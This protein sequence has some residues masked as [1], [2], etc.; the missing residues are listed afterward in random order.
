MRSTKQTILS[1]LA[2]TALA[3]CAFAPVMADDTE[4]FMVQPANRV[5]PNVLII[6]DTSGSMNLTAEETPLPYDPT[7]SYGPASG[8]DTTE[9]RNDR[10]YYSRNATPPKSCRNLSYIQLS[11]NFSAAAPREIKCQAAVKHLAWGAGATGAGFYTDRFI[12][13]RGSGKNRG[14][15]ADLTNGD[16]RTTASDVECLE[17]EG[18]H[19]ADSSSPGTYPDYRTADSSNGRWTN[20]S[21]DSWWGRNQGY[22]TTLYSPN[23]IRYLAY[24]SKATQTR[25]DVVR[26]AAAAFLNALPNLNVG[27][28]R[29]SAN[30]HTYPLSGNAAEEAAA[31]GMVMSPV[32]PLDPKRAS[33][34]ADITNASG[35]NLYL[36]HGYTPLSETLYEAYL[37][38]SGGPVH[39]GQSSRLCTRVDTRPGDNGTCAD[40]THMRNYPSVPESMSDGRYISPITSS[41]QTNY[42]VYLTDGEARQDTQ[43]NQA[44]AALTGTS[45]SGDGG[46]LANLT[47][48]MFE[49]D[50]IPDH[51][52]P[53]KQNVRTYFIGFGPDFSGNPQAFN[54][55]VTA[56][57]LGGGQAYQAD[58]LSSLTSVFNSIVTSILQ[59]S[60]T[61]TTPTVAVNA[62]NRTQ[63]LDDLFVSVFQPDNAAHWPGNLKKYR[64][65]DG[66]IVDSEGRAAVDPTTGFFADSARS[67]WSSRADGANVK[68]GGAANRIP[69]PEQR[70]LYTY[71]GAQRPGSAVPLSNHPLSTSNSDL[72]EE[73]LDLLAPGD[74][75]RDD[76]INWAR[77]ADVL[78]EDGDA[79]TNVRRAMGDPLHSPPAVVIYGGTA[80]SPDAVV[81]V[82]TNDGYLH[83]FD[84]ET[85]VELWAYV[86]QELL[87]RLKTLY[88][89]N[90]VAQRTYGLDSPITVL[91]YD[92]N[93][94]G[95]VN[96]DDRVIL[97]F[98]MGR[99]GDRYYA[100][101]V[102][103]KNR[104]RYL[105]SI[106]PEVLPG[107]GQTWSQ[108]TVARV[109][110][111]GATQNSQKLVL[112]AG[113]GYDVTQDSVV[114]GEDSVGNRLYM[115]DAIRGTL[116]WS[117][118]P[119]GANLN[120]SR[121]THSIPS[122]VAVLDTDSDGYADRM[123]VGDMAAQLWRFDITNGN[124]ANT[125]VAGGVIAS[126]GTKEHSTP[127]PEHARRFY[128][129]PDVAALQRADTPPI[130][131]IA[132]GSGY[133]GHPLN[134]A[135]QDRFYSIRDLQ[136]FRRLT[137]SEYNNLTIIRDSDL[138]DITDDV[139]A[140]V[141]ANAPGWK[142]LLNYPAWQGEKSL[143]PANTFDNKI[144]FTTYIPPGPA[145]ANPDTC[146]ISSSGRNRVYVVNAFNGA[147]IPRRDSQTD[148]D[149]GNG[150]DGTGGMSKEDRFEEL[151]QG[152]IAPE[153]SFLFPEANQVVCLSG[154]EVLGMCR[155]FNS[156]IKTYW[157]ESTAQ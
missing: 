62:F 17:D 32:S 125:L 83:A 109:N 156:R 124:S 21:T 86:P 117:A 71:I 122:A 40:A 91:K 68:A 154:V 13:W 96:G 58:D 126:L 9:C 143:S 61:F 95:I 50:L 132:I 93:G 15:Q 27:V 152:G 51:I 144:F 41:C 75:S 1:T 72:D 76:L 16:N 110:V 11:G 137:Q 56:A 88:F 131:N 48:Y 113:G 53:G 44:I 36:P 42:I 8:S 97:Y 149:G 55:L 39:F 139:Q 35:N 115:I 29:Y 74:P 120:L 82:T 38:Y 107:V 84:A 153:V 24:G 22:S 37:Y 142:L 102:T 3:L 18:E 59:T 100:I 104:P 140:I 151:A 60:T 45:C 87:P 69:P 150:G 31:G 112:I 108:P 34:I 28:M 89:N 33:L 135:T 43:A 105:W 146:S 78:N 106:G 119:S 141:P 47:Q 147:P 130:L 111:G 90:P 65:S 114:Y 133:R 118:G 67:Y 134:T 52:L 123:Y 101:D 54:R 73:V 25:M 26:A 66:E 12:R 10:I 6:L 46:C 103:D 64:V 19:G 85:G 98:G 57:T 127:Q 7:V 5:Q 49:N 94:D 80:E 157:R 148:P 77:G 2:G 20:V 14:W 70:N 99:G 81:Y 63:T 155:N 4:I 116:L 79:S 136:P 138:L 129:K 92:V 121:M 23:Y 128:N 145:E 30:S